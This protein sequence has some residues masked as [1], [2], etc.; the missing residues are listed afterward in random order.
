[1]GMA[2]SLDRALEWIARIEENG[3]L[4][5]YHLLPAAKADLLRRLGRRDEA[6]VAYTAAI[7]MTTNP[8]ERQYLERRMREC[9]G[10]V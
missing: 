1:M 5:S 10:P 4:A 6:V 7:A 9:G 8:A 3:A 2:T